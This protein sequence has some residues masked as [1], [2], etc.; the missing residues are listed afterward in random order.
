MKL[1]ATMITITSWSISNCKVVQDK[2]KE[3]R[4]I[5]SYPIIHSTTLFD[6]S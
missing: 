4:H 5:D 2:N 1:K 6:G 3:M